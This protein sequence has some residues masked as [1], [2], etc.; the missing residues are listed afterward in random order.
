[1]HSQS[2]MWSQMPPEAVSEVVKSKI[3]LG[4]MP[5]DPPSLAMFMQFPLP[6][7]KSCIKPCG[8]W[9]MNNYARLS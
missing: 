2:K 9:A 6:G 4:G 8:G 1:M 3:I 5:P 7:K